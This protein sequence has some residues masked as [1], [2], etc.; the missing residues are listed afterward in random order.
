MENEKEC[1]ICFES[2]SR[3]F[4]L[5]DSNINHDIDNGCRHWFCVQCL[6]QMYHAT[7]MIETCPLCR[8][9]ISILVNSQADDEGEDD[10][11]VT[12]PDPE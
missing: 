9:D 3:E 4:L 6:E 2:Y 11:T 10:D 5:K 8:R 7:P 12:A 1:V